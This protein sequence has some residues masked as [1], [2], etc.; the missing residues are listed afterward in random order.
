MDVRADLGIGGE[1]REIGVDL[2]RRAVVVAGADVDVAAQAVIFPEA[3]ERLVLRCLA[4]APGGRPAD[5]ASL[6]EAP[7]GAGADDWTQGEARVWWETTF[8][9]RPSS[10]ERVMP[11][12]EILEVAAPR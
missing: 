4:K 1:E 12:T 11:P 8:T 9:P 10:E 7:T 5:A 3:L 6:A 2:G